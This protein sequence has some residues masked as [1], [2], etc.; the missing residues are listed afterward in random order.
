MV[1]K[2]DPK[3]ER[4]ELVRT[5]EEVVDRRFE[6]LFEVLT[7]LSFGREKRGDRAR[8]FAVSMPESL[9]GELRKLGGMTSRH[10]CRAV[11]LYLAYLA[12]REVGDKSRKKRAEELMEK[13]ETLLRET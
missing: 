5:I 2:W 3:K 6:K 1:T 10:V 8:K 9:Y 4:E 12:V 7:E 13:L 11:R